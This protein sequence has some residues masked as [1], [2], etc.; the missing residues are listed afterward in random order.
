MERLLLQNACYQQRMQ[1]RMHYFELHTH[2]GRAQESVY[3][4]A[5]LLW[6]D[7]NTAEHILQ[8]CDY[9][10]QVDQEG[11]VDGDG[12]YL[13]D[14]LVDEDGLKAC[15]ASGAKDEDR[16]PITT[17]NENADGQWDLSEEHPCA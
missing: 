10:S 1:L 7:N 11:R 16:L 2:C 14:A 17:Q 5:R 15:R 12:A 9:A 3:H 13:R 8:E 4:E 6:Q